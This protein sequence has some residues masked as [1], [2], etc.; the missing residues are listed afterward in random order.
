MAQSQGLGALSFGTAMPK[1]LH[2]QDVRCQEF[3]RTGQ[4]M[5]RCARDT[6]PR[7]QTCCR[8]AGCKACWRQG[9][10]GCQLACTQQHRLTHPHAAGSS[11]DFT[12]PSGRYASCVLQDQKCRRSSQRTHE[13]STLFMHETILVW[14]PPSH[15]AEHAPQSETAQ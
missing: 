15:V 1:D 11:K 8:A 2:S 14:T 6:S 3:S 12:I 10:A 7:M 5:H 4:V 9:T 13:P